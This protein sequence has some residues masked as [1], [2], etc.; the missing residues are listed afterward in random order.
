LPYLVCGSGGYHNFSHVDTKNVP[1][2]TPNNAVPGYG[3][4]V[5]FEKYCDDHWGFLRVTI[6]NVN[7][8]RT[9]T[10]EY[11]NAPLPSQPITTQAVLFDSFQI[12]L[13]TNKIK[14]LM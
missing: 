13:T 3:D 2:N 1:V 11:F 8:L 7:G 12:N 6:E 10:A 4:N 14:N 5:T 9:L